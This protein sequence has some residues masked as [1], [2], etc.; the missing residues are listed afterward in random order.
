VPRRQQ[1]EPVTLRE[2]A[3]LPSAVALAG[4]DLLIADAGNNRVIGMP[5]Q[6]GAYVHMSANRVLGQDRLTPSPS[7]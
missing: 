7:T 2:H 1:R 3:G 5:Q 6:A 4:T